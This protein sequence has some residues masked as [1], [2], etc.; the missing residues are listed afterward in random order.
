[1]ASVE[2]GVRAGG[3]QGRIP[4]RD[5]DPERRVAAIM[6]AHG[7]LLLHVAYQWSLCHDDALDAYQRGLEI[8]FRRA[9]TVN[10]ATE[11]AWLKVVIKHEAL[12]IRR[13]RQDG[14]SDEDPTDLDAAV[15][16]AQRSLEEQVESGERVSR[17]AEAL[18]SLKPDEA[19]ALLLK[20]EGLSYAEIGERFGW[21]Y[22]KTNR[23]ITEGRKRFM[24]AYRA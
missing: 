12:A 23:A 21:T 20:A 24:K 8:F 19:K 9:H 6:S 16:A 15:P 18:R 4:L 1:M 3:V 22:T 14:V 5:D 13:S 2:V 10:P 7:R 11:V 17:S